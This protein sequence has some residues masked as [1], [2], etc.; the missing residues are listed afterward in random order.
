M[1]SVIGDYEG[2]P[3]IV[4]RDWVWQKTAAALL[5][6]G[7]VRINGLRQEQRIGAIKLDGHWLYSIASLRA[8]AAERGRTLV[9]E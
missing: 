1:A 4:L 9:G 3:A 2:P 5:G 7:P 6:V 8:Y